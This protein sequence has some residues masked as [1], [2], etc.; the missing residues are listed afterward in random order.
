MGYKGADGVFGFGGSAGRMARALHAPDDRKGPTKG[1]DFLPNL[2]IL[3]CRESD[4][5]APLD[6]VEKSLTSP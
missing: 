3:E 2:A 6:R 4:P 1:V 5:G